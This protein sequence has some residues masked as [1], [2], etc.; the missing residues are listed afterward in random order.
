M[1]NSWL[2]LRQIKIVFVCI[3][4]CWGIGTVSF[5]AEDAAA[6]D[7]NTLH[8]FTMV[9][10]LFGGLA[11]FL[12]GMEKMA[13]ALKVATGEHLKI[14]L[15]KLTTNRVTSVLTGA[16]VTAIIQSSSVTTVLV[17]G[18]ITA[19][20]MSFPQA[21]GDFLVAVLVRQSPHRSLHFRLTNTRFC[22]SR[23]V[24]VR[25]LLEPKTG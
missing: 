12:Y 4:L 23:W 18:F 21:I 9:M 16:L 8:V 5:A 10:G 24:S 25:Y 2:N 15:A 3:T 7:P 13:A 11:L 20:V 6:S 22:W 19:E 1:N 14:I 17:I